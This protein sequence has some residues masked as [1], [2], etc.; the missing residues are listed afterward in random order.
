MLRVFCSFSL[1][2]LW[3]HVS[4]QYP[5]RGQNLSS[6]SRWCPSDFVPASPDRR[7]YYFLIAL[8]ASVPWDRFPHMTDS[9]VNTTG[10]PHLHW[11]GGGEWMRAQLGHT[12]LPPLY[13]PVSSLTRF[14]PNRTYYLRLT[15][16]GSPVLKGGYSWPSQLVK[17][18]P[19][20]TTILCHLLFWLPYPLLCSLL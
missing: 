5:S 20:I 18:T 1:T 16:G 7:G 11:V 2:S 9:S 3:E 8:V 15:P 12:L 10:L 17:N 4:C 14:M 13:Q 19:H 6:A